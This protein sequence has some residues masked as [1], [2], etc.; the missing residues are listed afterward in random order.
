M[1]E[2]FRKQ[3][4]LI[5]TRVGTAFRCVVWAEEEEAWALCGGG[6][7]R[8]RLEPHSSDLK[9]PACMIYCFIF[10]SFHPVL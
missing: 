4:F 8:S 1:L 2:S 6:G 7:C 9:V 3:P 10:L 5:P